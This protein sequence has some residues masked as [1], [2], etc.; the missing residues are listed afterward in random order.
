MKF[1]INAVGYNS[2]EGTTMYIERPYGSGDYLFLFSTTEVDMYI[3]NK[4]HRIE[5]NTFMLYRPT[6]P[7]LYYEH[8]NGFTNDYFHFSGEHLGEFFLRMG[9]PMNT[10]TTISDDHFVR[11][12]IRKMESEYIRRDLFWEEKISIQVE[13]FFISLARM[14]RAKE[15]YVMNPYKAT[16]LEKFKNVREEVVTNMSLD[17]TVDDMAELVYLSRSRFSV[18]YKE[19]FGCGPK[20]DLIETRM[21]R[22]KYLLIA[23]SSPIHDIAERVGYDNVYHFSKQFKKVTGYSP[24]KYMQLQKAN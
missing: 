12:F 16:M 11:F 1:Q 2:I 15:D 4:K 20:E 7:Q 6:D 24:R 9:I 19:F 8:E 3:K 21:N 23:T 10:P 18:L 17:W 5:P 13:D 14:W 22:A